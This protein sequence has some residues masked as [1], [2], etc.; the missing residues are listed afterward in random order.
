MINILELE[1]MNLKCLVYMKNSDMYLNVSKWM[2]EK[3]SFNKWRKTNNGSSMLSLFKS[4]F[5]FKI[6]VVIKLLLFR[7]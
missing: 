2:P 6:S 5:E 1:V 4:K 3:K 7:Y